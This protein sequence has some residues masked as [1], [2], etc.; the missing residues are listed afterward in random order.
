M[1]TKT[2]RNLRIK[3]IFTFILAI[4]V[5]QVFSQENIKVHKTNSIEILE[6]E[7]ENGLT[8]FLNEDHAK[9][10]IFGALVTKAGGKD[11]PS[12][13]TGMAHYMEH[14]LFKGT[15]E[16]GTI[17]WEK[18]KPHI[19]KIFELYDQLGKTKDEEERSKIQ[20]LINEESVKANKYA[21]PNELSNIIKSMGGTKLNAGTGRDMTIFYNL[22]PPNQL[23]KWLELYSHRFINPVFRS[24]Q[25]EL[26]VVYEEKNMYADNFGTHMIETF[27]FYFFKNHPYG[28]QTLI[29]T[30]EDLKN[31]SLTK[32]YDFFKTYY[33]PNNMAL[34]LS[35][36]FNNDEVIPVIKENFGKW[37]RGDVP[38]SVEYKEEPFN[39]REFHEGKYSPIKLEILG[40]RTVTKGHLDEPALEICN[41]I[42]SNQDQTGLLDKL[43]LD[44]KI[45][46]AQVIPMPF[47]D[48]GATLVLI[49]PKIAGQVQA[50]LQ[51]RK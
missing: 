18:E 19:E 16:L 48:H 33:V 29:G 8:V 24:F 5:I 28:Q 11:D 31:P 17:D 42:L 43:S 46:M 45:M 51:A 39:G 30:I 3:A 37:L 36:D 27:L 9:P 2:H 40:F 6:F 35:G 50:C 13:A 22:F 26:E 23:E 41:R 49:I 4:A 12:D 14:M 10:E 47:K 15:E 21:I 25:A 34:V 38:E 7:L 1:L 32:M 44:N 20:K